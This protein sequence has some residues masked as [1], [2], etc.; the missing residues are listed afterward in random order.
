MKN[1]WKLY[2]F[3]VSNGGKLRVAEVIVEVGEFGAM[4]GSTMTRQMLECSGWS[5]K[6]QGL[7]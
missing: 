1:S 5:T 4:R 6:M 3:L 2:N 7:T